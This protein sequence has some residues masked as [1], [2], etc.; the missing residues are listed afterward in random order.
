MLHLPLK[1]TERVDIQRS[2]HRFIESAYSP[3]QADEHR[4][5]CAEVQTLR[6]LVRQVPSVPGLLTWPRREPARWPTL[7]CRRRHR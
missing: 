5:A 2:L 4:D 7:V 3:A 6:E 1:A